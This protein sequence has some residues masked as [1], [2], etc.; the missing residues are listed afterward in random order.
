MAADALVIDEQSESR[1]ERFFRPVDWSAFW[2][3][4]IVAFGVYFYTMAPTVGL[5]DAGE[6]AVAGDYLGVPHPPGYPIWTIIS[7]FFA[8][9]F[10]FITFRGQPNPAWAVTLVSVVFGAITS[11]MTAMLI[12]RSG[13]DLLAASREDSHTANRRTDALICWTG[14]VVGSL[15]F[16]FSPVMWSQSVIIEVYSLNAFF[17]VLVF[18]LSYWWMRRPTDKLLFVTAFVFGLGLTNYQVLLLAA[19]ALVVVILLR[20]V[21]LFRDFLIIGI[22]FMVTITIMKLASLPPEPNFGKLKAL[23]DPA[24]SSITSHTPLRLTPRHY[25]AILFSLA[26]VVTASLVARHMWKPRT[27]P[28][29]PLAVMAVGV[30]VLL[31]ALSRIPDAAPVPAKPD[32][33]VFSWG[34]YYLGF[35]AMM[36]ALVFLCVSIPRGHMLAVALVAIEVTLA[37]LLR[38]GALFSLH[39][40]LSLWF[41]FYIFL[42]FLFLGL[43]WY[44]LP[45]GRTVALSFL[46]AELGVAFYAYMPIV[47]DLRNPPMNWAYPRTWEGFK[48]AI[49]RGQYERIA[50]ANAFS[51]RFLHQIG[52]Y[53]TDLR[54]QFTLPIALLGFL[55]FTVWQMRAFGRRIKALNVAITLSIA[56]SVFVVVEKVAFPG[57]SALTT[58]YKLLILGVVVMLGAGGLALFTSQA[59]EMLARLPGKARARM[60]ERVTLGLV[61][62]GAVMLYLLYAAMLSLSIADVT[63]PLRDASTELAPGQ[64]RDII[65]QVAGLI[66]LIIG[67]AVAVAIIAWLMDSRHEFRVVIDHNSQQWVIATLIGFLAMSIVLI[68]LANPKGDIQDSFIQRVKFISSHALYAF[69]IG[70]GLIFGLAFVDTLFRN[71]TGI[72]W[73]SIGTALCLALVPLQ[74]NA[75]NSELIRK[76]GGAEQH[77]HDFGWQ[78]GNYQLRGAAAISEELAP[79]EEPLPNPF[80]PREMTRDAVFFGGTDPGRFVPTYMIYSARVREDVYLITQ[81]ALADNTYMSV[82]RDL[83]G[84]Q[85]WIPAQ[86][87]SAKA[88]QRYVDEVKSGKRRRNADLRIENG[89][90]QVSGALGVMEINGIL[91]QMIFEYNN[92]KHDF[93]VEES[94]V[95]PWMYRYLTPHGLIMKINAE[96]SRLTPDIIR[97]DQYFWDWYTRRLLSDAKFTRDVVARKSFSKL[98]SAIGGLYSNRMKLRDAEEAFQQARLLYP[99]SPEAN[100]RLVQEV[101][102]RRRRFAEAQSVMKTFGEADPGNVKVPKFLN[103]LERIQGITERIRELEA[104]RKQGRMNATAALELAELYRQAGQTSLFKQ[105]M[106]GILKTKNL[107]YRVVFRAAQL[108]ANAKQYGQMETALQLY[109]ERL[110]DDAKPQHLLT[111]AQMYAQAQNPARMSDV[112]GRYLARV[113]NDWRAWLDQSALLLTLRKTGPATKALEQALRLGGNKALSIVRTDD[114]FTPIRNKAMQQSQ[115]LMGLPRGGAGNGESRRPIPGLGDG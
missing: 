98:R 30:V 13:A 74:Q 5:E 112:L 105:M 91:A 1:S 114:R 58:V 52:A 51:L 66:L 71:N 103:H 67:P 77:G 34:R 89:R 50:P 16:S 94:Y 87:D 8:R 14:G 81:N 35:L 19:L 79:D 11:G 18:L 86:P 68:A 20:D 37:V 45:R 72:K 65:G 15:I 100:F 29:I 80:F 7:W 36:G 104:T 56:A 46:M 97:K 76:L 78:F 101:L 70:Y 26:T 4:C 109:L 93:Y 99:L 60:S 75:T 49:T 42:N 33:E 53:L 23:A 44:A 92:Y 48:H 12:S 38:K 40:P 88:F 95:I 85:I 113:P 9:V 25:M 61:L 31:V 90:V 3:S 84:D 43:A 2:A 59:R 39:H 54:E 47:S 102:M 110:P 64:M 41:G 17:L 69:W 28:V 21:E 55:P 108:L 63:A 24:F 27:W 83:Y 62:I 107:D 22:L 73:L 106:K 96:R 32:E 82:M 10:G 6:L 57:G 111:V 115:R